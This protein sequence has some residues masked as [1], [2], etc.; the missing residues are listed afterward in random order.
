MSNISY[1]RLGFYEED[2]SQSSTNPATA[3]IG[4]LVMSIV[5]SKDGTTIYTGTLSS[6]A[7]ELD[8]TKLIQVGKLTKIDNVHLQTFPT[9][10][11]LPLRTL[12]QRD[13]R[14]G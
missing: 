6:P 2:V 1:T 11:Q 7:V 4:R 3:G 13:Q 14:P 9:Q 10:P 12:S 8:P 5:A